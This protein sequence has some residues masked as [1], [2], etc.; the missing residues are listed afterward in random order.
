MFMAGQSDDA[1]NVAAINEY[2]MTQPINTPASAAV[3][4]EWLKWH[5]TLGWYQQQ[6]TS[7]DNYD[8]ARNL[9][10]KFNEANATT[11]EEKAQVKYIQQ[12]GLSSEELRGETDR[13]TSDGGYLDHPPESE[14][15]IPTK[16]KIAGVLIGLSAA[17]LWVLKKTYIDPFLPSRK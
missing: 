8:A 13:R 9:R 12:T 6:F 7:T 10:N 14:P 1:A 15:W 3:K 11:A 5:D 17:A 2:I 16:T 4:D